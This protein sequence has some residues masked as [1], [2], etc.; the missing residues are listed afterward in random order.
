MIEKADGRR[1][2]VPLSAGLDSRL[3]ASG[4]KEEKYDNVECFSYGLKNNY[5]IIAGRK[6]S[7]KLQYK[8][9]KIEVNRSD[10]IDFYKSA[11]Y[12]KYLNEVNDGVST[13][14]NQ[15][16]YII[17]FLKKNNFLK[18]DDIL[19]NGSCGDFVSGGHVANEPDHYIPMNFNNENL[20]SIVLK[21]IDKHYSL[22]GGLFNNKNVNKISNLVKSNI[23]KIID[24]KSDLFYPYGIFETLEYENRQSKYVANMQKVYDSH[25][26]NWQMPLYDKSFFEFWSEV[27]PLF[28]VNQNLYKSVLY[29]MDMG[30]VWSK[31]WSF[32]YKPHKNLISILRDISKIF[33]IFK[34][35]DKW[36][37]VDRKYFHYWFD[38]ICAYYAVPY[39]KVMLNNYDPRNSVS[40]N[41]LES[42]KILFGNNWQDK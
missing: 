26:L 23:L 1:I 38:I 20:H 24:N 18:P 7:E 40:W 13:P 5:E 15:D 14:G 4:L 42:E 16:N 28:K 34:D 6:I 30:G 8:W 2:I 35:K 27:P 33:F 39:K 36:R 9:N 29:E 11:F 19:I 31:E 21:Y 22:W 3:I 41:T 32:L 17:S 25:N 37:K 10:A 12:K